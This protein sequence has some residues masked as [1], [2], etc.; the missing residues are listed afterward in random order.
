M[1]LAL[2]FPGQGSQSQGML[3]ALAAEF[4]IVEK[5]FSQASQV[6]GY[7]LWALAQQG[8]IEQ[9]NQTEFT[10]PALLAADIAA[11]YCWK[12]KGGMDPTVVAGHSL[13]EYAALVSAGVLS[14]EDAIACVAL[15]GK[16]MQEAVP[17]GEGAMAAIIG[18][19]NEKVDALCR[20]A[21][22]GDVVS[23]AN[24]NSNGQVVISGQ[25]AA[26]ERAVLLAKPKGAKLAK[27]IPVSVPS[28]CALMQPAAVQLAK[29][30]TDIEFQAPTFPVIHNV[31]ATSYD[32]P[33]AIQ[34]ALLQQLT[35]P[36]RWV[37]TILKMQNDQVGLFIEVGPGKVLSGLN[38]RITKEVKTV[39]FDT[40][41]LLNA[42][43]ITVGENIACL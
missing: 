28:H 18:L 29:K 21:S 42:A 11:W 5:T 13:G 1:K 32:D 23:S 35:Q 33:D 9:L 41:E 2:L 34:E 36:V 31:D 24:F 38:K 27:L 8:P 7:D 15:R 19:D 10:Q 26:V 25:K 43:L 17:A 39:N 40:P 30:L 6:L 4:P 37:D 16:A 14:F 20:E 22:Q 12:E 3:A